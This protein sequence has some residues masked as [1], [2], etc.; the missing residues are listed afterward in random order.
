MLGTMLGSK[1]ESC[2]FFPMTDPWDEPYIYLHLHKNQ[3]NVGRCDV[4]LIWSY[5]I[6]RWN[7]NDLFWILTKVQ[8]SQWLPCRLLV[9]FVFPQD[10]DFCERNANCCWLNAGAYSSAMVYY[11]SDQWTNLSFRIRYQST[12]FVFIMF[13]TFMDSGQIIATYSRPLVIPNGGL[14]KGIPP[15]CSCNN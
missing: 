2:F 10:L 13:V 5:G 3:P 7:L 15:K 12:A 6:Y 4:P 11:Y 14:V 8:C 9:V 1:V